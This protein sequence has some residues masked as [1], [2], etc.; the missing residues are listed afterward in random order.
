[1]PFVRQTL[2]GNMI[3]YYKACN[4]V[5]SLKFPSQRQLAVPLHY[6]QWQV[7]FSVCTTFIGSL[8]VCNYRTRRQ[9]ACLPISSIMSLNQFCLLSRV[10]F[11]SLGACVLSRARTNAQVCERPCVFD[12]MTNVKSSHQGQPEHLIS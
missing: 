6:F 3:V 12:R 4:T 8:C 5:G 2:R 9:P 1:M 11:L 7:T 10:L